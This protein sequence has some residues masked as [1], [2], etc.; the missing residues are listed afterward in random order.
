MKIRSDRHRVALHEAGHVMAG[1]ALGL[2]APYLVLGY[3]D[4]AGETHHDWDR[5]AVDDDGLADLA[6]M[7]LAGAA[8]LAEFGDPEPDW[9]AAGDRRSAL[10]IARFLDP[11]RAETL[12]DELAERSGSIC[13]EERGAIERFADT[14]LAHGRLAGDEV[15]EAIDGARRGTV[16]RLDAETRFERLRARRRFFEDLV[17]DYMTPEQRAAA[18]EDA[19][20][21]AM[22]PDGW[23]PAWWLTATQLRALPHRGGQFTATAIDP[24]AGLIETLMRIAV[25]RRLGTP[26]GRREQMELARSMG[27]VPG[28]L[29]D[30][31]LRRR[32]ATNAKPAPVIETTGGG[33][34]ARRGHHHADPATA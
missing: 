7:D 9:G 1:A 18:W 33:Q 31:A 29:A 27:L 34:E 24:D 12:L 16:V 4:A 11:A 23:L 2:P 8:A 5:L 25:P 26:I 17:Q 15:T 3:R 22:D 21:R 19:G 6:T 14:L 30:L 13:A 28:N 10:G 20:R 32:I